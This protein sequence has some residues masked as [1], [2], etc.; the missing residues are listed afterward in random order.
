MRH[1]RTKKLVLVLTLVLAGCGGGGGGDHDGPTPAPTA[2]ATVTGPPTE[3]PLPSPTASS[4]FAFDEIVLG[5]A[6][7]YGATQPN[8]ALEQQQVVL[9]CEAGVW[10]SLPLR[11]QEPAE[12]AG[13]TFASERFAYA[14]GTQGDGSRGLLLRS[15]DAGRTWQDLSDRL[16]AAPS[17]ILDVAFRDEQV[18]YL[19]GRAF[20]SQP[21]VLRTTDG[22]F[23]WRAVAIPPVEGVPIFGNYALGFRGDAVELVRFDGDGIVVVRL[24]DRTVPPIVI[25]P[26]GGAS[27]AGP[28]GFSTAGSVGWIAEASNASILRSDAPGASWQRQIVDDTTLRSLFAIDVRGDHVG[29]AG[30]ADGASGPFGPLL[31]ATDDGV[32][33]RPGTVDLFV[34]GQVVDVLRLRGDAALAIVNGF[35]SDPASLV[36]RSTDGARTWHHEPTPFEVDWQIHD[37]ARNTERAE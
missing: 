17:R 13:V 7:R 1:R 12:V 35:D 8:G 19:V 37:L 18:G 21:A 30:G 28:N 34:D 29:V 20:F 16:P 14:F 27:F 36:L 11:V 4:V 22:G 2:T 25:E 10:E 31:L 5:V 9:R 26:A 24:N 33:W 6:T 32:T 15:V 3:T 23:S